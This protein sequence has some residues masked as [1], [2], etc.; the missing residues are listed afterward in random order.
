[1]PD[2][3]RQIVFAWLMWL[4]SSPL[5]VSI[6]VVASSCSLKPQSLRKLERSYVSMHKENFKI[7]PDSASQKRFKAMYLG[8]GGIA[9]AR[10]NDLILID[11]FFSH[12]SISR[13][14]KSLVMKRGNKATLRSDPKMINLGLETLKDFFPGGVSPLAIASSHSHY[15][16]LMDIPWVYNHYQGNPSLLLTESGYNIVHKTTKKEDVILLEDHVH[17]KGILIQGTN[18]LVRIQPIESEHNPHFRNVKFFDGRHTSPTDGPERPHDKSS[19]NLWLEGNTFSFLIDFLT[20][21]NEIEFRV[22][23]QS[24]SCHAPAGIPSAEQLGDRPIDLAFVGLVSYAFSPPYPCDLLDRIQPRN[25]VWVHWED[26]FRKYNRKPKTVRGTDVPVFFNIPCVKKY[27]ETGKI[28]WPRVG[29]EV[30]Y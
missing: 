18:G 19:A 16:H 11:P 8:C 26:F 29:F 23:I 4:R 15:D 22:F 1:M 3:G 20:P 14:G 13:I 9:L 21:D 7:V 17:G 27:E 25:V 24:S 5:L 12:Q 10:E 2:H 6:F 28:V 30:V